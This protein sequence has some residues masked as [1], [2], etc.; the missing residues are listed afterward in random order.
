MNNYP[1]N[2]PNNRNG[3]GGN[4]VPPRNGNVQRPNGRQMPDPNRQRSGQVVRRAPSPNG[5]TP[6]TTPPPQDPRRRQPPPQRKSD[7]IGRL[8]RIAIL[9]VAVLLV[10]LLIIFITSYFVFPVSI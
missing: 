7:G 10:V 6:R 8:G 2:N 1:N 9:W 5:R 3:Q 4:R